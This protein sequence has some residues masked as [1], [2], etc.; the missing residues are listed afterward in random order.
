MLCRLLQR[1]DWFTQEKAALLLTAILVARP[2]RWLLLPSLVLPDALQ[3]WQH[4]LTC[5]GRGSVER[6]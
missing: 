2:N 3:A 6:G 4:M 1:T 5:I